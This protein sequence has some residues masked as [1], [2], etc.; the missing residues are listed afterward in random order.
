MSEAHDILTGLLAA[1]P[2]SYQKTIGFPT[3]DLLAAVALRQAET[4]GVIADAVRRLDPENL[5]G[6]GLD[7]Y[8]YPR[9]G[10]VRHPA[11]FA[12]GVLTVS[13][14]GTVSQGDLFESAGG[15]QFAATATVKIEGTGEVPVTC[16]RDGRAGNLPAHS[17]TLM[18]VTLPG[19]VSCDNPLPMTE[20]YD[21]ESDAAYLTRFYAKLRTPPTSGNIYHYRNW[22]LDVTGVGDAL[23]VPLGHGANTVDVVLIDQA[24]KPASAALVAEVQA[25]IDPDSGG[26][27]RGEA[28]IGAHCYVSAAAGKALA[29]RLTVSKLDTATTDGTTA[30]IRAAV[31]DYLG[32]IAFQQPFV[33]FAKIADA[34]M[35]A[36]G[37]RDYEGLTVNGGTANVQLA[38]REVA[39]LGTLEV[40]YA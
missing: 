36:Q 26:D 32:S 39:V 13:G 4:D 21:E 8:I 38:A 17:V 15:V 29:V 22:A 20:G 1:V 35:G 40:T 19:I 34:V 9:S 18:P 23:V 5:T 2:D 3:Y 30:A 14:S 27:G 6:S 7:G 16:R 28:P 12:A 24:G 25:Y 11:T 10:L 31:T 37:V 33:S